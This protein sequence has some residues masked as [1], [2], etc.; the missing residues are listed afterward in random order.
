ML[1][2]SLWWLKPEQSSLRINILLVTCIYYTYYLYLHVF[3]F[4][5]K[6]VS[7]LI[8]VCKRIAQK[9]KENL[10]KGNLKF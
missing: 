3:Q 1:I 6:G 7:I 2:V 9:A 10:R 4:A 5:G 8:M